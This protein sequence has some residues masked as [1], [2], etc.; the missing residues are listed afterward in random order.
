MLPLVNSISKDKEI[1]ASILYCYGAR[2]YDPKTSVFLGVDPIS[3]KYPSW[4]A[5]T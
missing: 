3:D 5:F 2:Y 1:L 4:S